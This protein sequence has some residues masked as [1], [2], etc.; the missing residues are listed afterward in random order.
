MVVFEWES[1]SE[2]FF[3]SLLSIHV[4][5]FVGVRLKTGSWRRRYVQFYME[6]KQMFQSCKG[7]YCHWGFSKKRGI[8]L[9]HFMKDLA[10]D[11]LRFM[12]FNAVF[13][14]SFFC[15]VF[16][17]RWR[18]HLA[19]VC[20]YRPAAHQSC[21]G[22][23]SSCSGAWL[24]CGGGWEGQTCWSAA[25][26]HQKTVNP[27]SSQGV[28][29]CFQY[30]GSTVVSGGRSVRGIFHQGDSWFRYGGLQCMAVSLVALAK[31][32]LECVFMAIT[33][34]GSGCSCR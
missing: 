10:K 12:L 11:Q 21:G 1:R 6:K 15:F 18:P 16:C 33:D 20:L 7:N 2:I 29:L 13:S 22:V 31:H 30:F 26:I 3:I 8:V 17:P 25:H 27:S 24:F 23:C 32:T 34:I 14:L 9:E 19:F 4:V 5:F 28:P